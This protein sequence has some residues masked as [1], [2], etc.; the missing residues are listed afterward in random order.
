M[1]EFPNCQVTKLPGYQIVRLQT[2]ISTKFS[3]DQIVSYQIVSHQIVSYQIV[4][5]PNC[6]V[7]Q[8]VRL[9]NCQVT[10]IV[11]FPKLSGYQTVRL[12]KL[13]ATKLSGFQISV[14]ESSAT[15]LFAT[16][17]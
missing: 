14:T 1:L 9:P 7:T 13:L 8:I 4:R 12:P 15:K 5:L 10:Q 2:C 3:G 17:L 16:K 6:Q 11:R